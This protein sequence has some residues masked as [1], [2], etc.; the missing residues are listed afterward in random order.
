MIIFYFHVIFLSSSEF[1]PVCGIIEFISTKNSQNSSRVSLKSFPS[2][3]MQC[4]FITVLAVCVRISVCSHY[5]T[6]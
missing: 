6:A 3:A 5:S 2:C 1:Q 4:A